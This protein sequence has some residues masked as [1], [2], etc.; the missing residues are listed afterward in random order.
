MV[1]P[2]LFQ[3]RHDL[4]LDLRELLFAHGVHLPHTEYHVVDRKLLEIQKADLLRR[5]SFQVTACAEHGLGQHLD[6]YLCQLRKLPCGLLIQRSAG[7]R[8]KH[9]GIRNDGRTQKPGNG[10]GYLHAILL[11]HLV[12]DGR[13]TSYRL[14]TEKDR[15]H[16]L[17]AAQSVVVNDLQHI[18]LLDPVDCLALFI[19]VHQ[20]HLLLPAV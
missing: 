4:F 17:N 19:V 1:G 14:V 3:M 15:P 7:G 6:I 8:P 2:C 18:R 10:S 16:G 11:V 12:H 13:G 20:D 5:L 9:Q